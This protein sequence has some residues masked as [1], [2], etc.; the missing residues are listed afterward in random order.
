MPLLVQQGCLIS[1][2]H[3]IESSVPQPWPFRHSCPR[4]K[5]PYY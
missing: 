2:H 4:R 3:Q 5:R 1:N